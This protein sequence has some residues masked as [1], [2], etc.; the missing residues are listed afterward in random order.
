[1]VKARLTFISV[2]TIP[3]V[4]AFVFLPACQPKCQPP[5]TKTFQHLSDSSWR[6]VETTNPHVTITKFDFI[7]IQFKRD[8]TGDV[9]V[10]KQNQEFQNPVEVFTWAVP[11]NTQGSGPLRIQYSTPGDPG[12]G[13]D[14]AAT[15]PE[16]LDTEDYTFNL[17]NQL[18][19]TETKTGYYW[20]FVPMA[21]IVDPDTNCTF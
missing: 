8:F 17:T 11:D 2:I 14:Q 9:L 6:A 5:A 21:G 12:N 13:Q 3:L 10:V 15:P 1:L 7:E 19:L 20:R 18:E 4:A 16:Q